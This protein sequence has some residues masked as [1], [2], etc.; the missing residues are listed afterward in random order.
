MES[1]LMPAKSSSNRKTKSLAQKSKTKPVRPAKPT[2]SLEV[3]VG[4]EVYRTWVSMLHSLVPDGRTHRLAPLVAAMLH[5]AVGK[6]DE[7]T[8]AEEEEENSVAQALLD[9]T[10]VSDPSEVKELLHEVVARLFKD[11]GVEYRRTSSRGYQYSIEE[12]AYQEYLHWY[13]MPWE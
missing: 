4:G 8:D 13:D 9:S 6:A 2:R 3:V 7:A 12:D 10:E 1:P 11:A 5:Y